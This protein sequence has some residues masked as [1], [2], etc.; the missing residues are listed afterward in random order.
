MA[1]KHRS[2]SM[3]VVSIIDTWFLSFWEYLEAQIFLTGP[4]YEEG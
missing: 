2:I 1:C 3:M 4:L